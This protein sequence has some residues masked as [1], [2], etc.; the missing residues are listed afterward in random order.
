MMRT[1]TT[2]VTLILVVTML[3]P[4]TLLADV[5]D[6]AAQDSSATRFYVDLLRARLFLGL[7]GLSVTSSS[8]APAGF[9]EA[10]AVMYLSCHANISRNGTGVKGV[11]MRLRA[12]VVN[13]SNEFQKVFGQRR[14]SNE[15]GDVFF[16]Q[17][18]DAT[19]RFFQELLAASFWSWAISPLG[20]KRANALVGHCILNMV[21][22][23]VNP[24]FIFAN[25]LALTGNVTNHD[26][27]SRTF[28]FGGQTWRYAVRDRVNAE[29][30]FFYTFFNVSGGSTRLTG[31]CV[32]DMG[33]PGDKFCGRKG[34]FD[35]KGFDDGVEY[36]DKLR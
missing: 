24:L 26:P 18:I 33:R 34:D 11:P 5:P 13:T 7:L 9:A 31:V 21:T 16:F 10:V 14:R 1:K 2:L 3:T 28:V 27:S 36:R 6:A 32:L 30:A 29:S 4:S 35:E 8:I 22:S 19:H 12:D 17:R 23:A 25:R 20:N 15:R